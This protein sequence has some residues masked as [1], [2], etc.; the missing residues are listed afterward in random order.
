MKKILLSCLCV[1]ASLSAKGDDFEVGEFGHSP[2][3]EYI[4]KFIHTIP[5]EVHAFHPSDRV[6]MPADIARMSLFLCEP[7]SD[8]INGQTL[9]VDG[10]ATVKMIY[11]E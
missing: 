10:G 2:T 8:F 6:G 11:P 9:T 7:E 3:S 1:L 5:S 4:P